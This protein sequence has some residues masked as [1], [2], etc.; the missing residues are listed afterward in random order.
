[1][2]TPTA[3]SPLANLGRAL[4]VLTLGLLL[5]PAAFAQTITVK[6]ATLAPEGTT[7]YNGLRQIGDR[8]AEISGGKVQV[9]IYAG[10]VAGNE[11]TQVRKMR[12]GQLHGA[13]LTNLGLLDIDAG[14]QVINTP[15]LIR[16][17]DEL[18]CVMEAITPTLDQRLLDKG[19]VVLSWSDAGWSHYF[20]RAPAS[21]PADAGKYKV[22][23]WEGDP[24]AVIGFR[25][26][27]LN[28]VVVQSV[29]V[30]P[31]LQ[32]GLIDGFFSTPLASLSLQWFALAPNML[33][34]PWAPLTG[35]TV[36]TK[37]AWDAIP[38][39]Y[40]EPFMAAAREVGASLKDEIRRQDNAA[41]K[42]ME[43]Y[44]LTVVPADDALIKQWTDRAVGLY[45]YF[46]EEIVPPEVF[47]LTQTTVEA[48]RAR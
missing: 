21:T 29:E 10:G 45:P 30:I 2:T 35:A 12:I 39:E 22:W 4:M 38:A 1:M 41:I 33:D 6:M 14:P 40:H 11:G 43:K 9:K 24:A 27:G 20:N 46:R 34:V 13:G 31:S 19:F 37:E 3:R 18:D 26:M 36:I 8:W 48:C 5:A 28:P 42:V 7:W 15:M 25:K 44:G 23:A 16:S 17:Y 47:D 32:S